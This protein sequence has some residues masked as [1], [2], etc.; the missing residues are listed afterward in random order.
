MSGVQPNQTSPAAPPAD[1][2]TTLATFQ[3]GR[4][5]PNAIEAIVDRLAFALAIERSEPATPEAV[6]RLRQDADRVLADFAFRYLHN[7]IDEIRRDAVAE[8]LGRLRQPPGFG[9]LVA[10]SL[11]GGGVI[12]AAGLWLALHPATLAGLAG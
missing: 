9:R 12:A 6:A 4:A 1:A 5:T 3:A 11:L 7:H 8:Q 10:A 2:A